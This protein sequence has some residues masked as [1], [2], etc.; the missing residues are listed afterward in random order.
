MTTIEIPVKIKTSRK[1]GPDGNFL[2][3]AARIETNRQV[4]TF[5]SAQALYTTVKL[6][7]PAPPG[8]AWWGSD[9]IRTGH[10]RDDL[11]VMLKDGPDYTVQ[12]LGRYPVFVNYGTRKMPANPFFQHSVGHVK[13]EVLPGLVKKWLK[14]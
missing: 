13:R 4:I 9:Y 14:K 7:A 2:D 12:V 6:L 10:L 11:I 5:R 1:F 3:L 8:S